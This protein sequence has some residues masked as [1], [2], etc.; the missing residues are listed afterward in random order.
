MALGVGIGISAVLQNI[1]AGGADYIANFMQQSVPPGVTFQRITARTRF[2]SNRTIETVAVDQPGFDYD[3]VSGL[4]RGLQIEEQRANLFLQGRTFNASPWSS[5]GQ[6]VTPGQASIF[7]DN[8]GFMLTGSTV[9]NRTIQSLGVNPSTTYV[10]WVYCSPGTS[11]LSILAVDDVGDGNQ[12]AANIN[13]SNGTIVSSGAR[14]ISNPFLIPVGGGRYMA[15]FSMATGASTT[16][17]TPQIKAGIGTLYVDAA[18]FEAGTFPTSFIPTTTA[19]ATRAAD[20]CSQT[21]GLPWFNASQGSVIAEYILMTNVANQKIITFSP[22]NSESDFIS[23][24]GSAS[25]LNATMRSGSGAVAS[26]SLGASPPMAVNKAGVAFRAFDLAATLNG[27]AVASSTASDFPVGINA[28]YYGR[29]STALTQLT[30][31][32]LRRISYYSMRLPNTQLQS[33]TT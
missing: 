23:L 4:L 15:G 33:L 22:G 25:G 3:P 31:G 8:Q 5:V 27:S 7:G 16:S 32:W 13:W 30:N 20:N 24:T 1:V 2:N 18:Q 29:R 9:S 11:S 10:F 19:S 28:A 6:T 26:A 12:A 21:G 17:A 14:P